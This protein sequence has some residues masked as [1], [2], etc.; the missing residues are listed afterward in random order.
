M[1]VHILLLHNRYDYSTCDIE[2]AAKKRGWKVE[3]VTD[4]NAGELIKDHNKV[5]YFGNTLQFPRIVDQLPI[6]PIELNPSLL[7]LNQDLAKRK[8]ATYSLTHLFQPFEEDLF[9]KP[10]GDKFFEARVYK[11]GESLTFND[12]DFVPLVG[13]EKDLIQVSYP[14]K[15][16]H[17]EIRC[18]C[19]NGSV[20]TA[21]YYRMMGGWKQANCDFEFETKD[22]YPRG[23]LD[24]IFEMVQELYVRHPEL[25]PGTVFD[26]GWNLEK[27]WFLIEQNQSWA[28][29]IYSCDPD[30]CLESIINSVKTK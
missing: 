16:F 29:S 6:T 10:F 18:F 26:F 4:F 19:L 11:K 20:L 14:E 8:V 3:R 25:P 15:Y 30:K 5:Y 23:S 24:K 1:S 17:S 22:G 2:A 28:S 13:H 27:D 12:P 21:S 9:C 7:G